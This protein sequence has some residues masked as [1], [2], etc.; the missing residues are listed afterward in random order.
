MLLPSL[1]R[2][3]WKVCYR[4]EVYRV[5]GAQVETALPAVCTACGCL[6]DDIELRIRDG[7]VT[8]AIHTCPIGREWFLQS[9]VPAGLAAIKGKS[10]ELSAAIDLAVQI[11]SRAQCP[12]VYGL[13]QA[14]CEA[15]SLAV[16]VASRL[17]AVLDVDRP[18]ARQVAAGRHHGM[19]KCS[20]A[21][22]RHRADLIVIW[23]ANP[24]LTH[25]RY[26]ERYIG[27]DSIAIAVGERNHTSEAAQHFLEV[28]KERAV[29]LVRLVLAA[30]RDVPASDAMATAAGFNPSELR[31]LAIRMR[32]CRFGVWLFDDQIC[33]AEEVDAIFALMAQL[34]RTTHW[35]ALNLGSRGN[36]T[37]ALNMIASRIGHPPPIT[38]LNGTARHESDF[39]GPLMLERGEIDA[40]LLVSPDCNTLPALRMTDVPTILIRHD[41]SAIPESADVTIVTATPGLDAGG[42]FH[43][44][45]DVP[46]RLVTVRS[47]ARPSDEEVLEQFLKRLNPLPK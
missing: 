41:H 7:Q 10:V 33:D 8:D 39:A 13:S 3:T 47:A 30:L 29:A 5:P 4:L 44:A 42:T 28:P 27:A 11:L 34:N 32:S 23:R 12:L 19:R 37:G 16:D 14:S 36:A 2:H 21:G 45:D 26:F 43:R 31:D 20:L 9:D 35:A 17:R 38:F 18:I 24:L 22:L 6:C 15:Q 1:S 25:P 40:L 46:L